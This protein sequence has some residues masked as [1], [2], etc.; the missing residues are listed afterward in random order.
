MSSI[1]DSVIVKFENISANG[2]DLM[3][4]GYVNETNYAK[5]LEIKEQINYEIMVILQNECVELAYNTQT[6]YVKK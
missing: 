2:I 4:V 3:I 1:K 6:V 5:Y